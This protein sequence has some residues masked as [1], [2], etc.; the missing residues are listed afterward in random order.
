MWC[1]QSRF[2]SWQRCK[3]RHFYVSA[4]GDRAGKHQ[5]QWGGGQEGIWQLS[6]S[7]AH[8]QELLSLCLTCQS[9]HLDGENYALCSMSWPLNCLSSDTHHVSSQNVL[10]GHKAFLFVQNAQDTKCCWG[11]HSAYWWLP[12]HLWGWQIILK[13]FH[14]YEQQRSIFM[15]VGFLL[16]KLVK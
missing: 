5:W 16:N 12:L 9:H 11:I 6:C 3:S 1:G 14:G 13:Q 2:V 8:Q 15:L 4:D 7:S 10:Q